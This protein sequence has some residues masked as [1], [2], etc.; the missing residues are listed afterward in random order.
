[1]E[2][3]L[4]RA[5]RMERDA[6]H[7]EQH[8]FIAIATCFT[9]ALSAEWDEKAVFRYILSLAAGALVVVYVVNR[10]S[11]TVFLLGLTAEETFM[12]EKCP[13]A[14][15]EFLVKFLTIRPK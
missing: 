8:P 4:H 9:M 14:L 11:L 2:E 12:T 5:A 7:E 3:G 13:D 6:V 10:E 15:S 1:M